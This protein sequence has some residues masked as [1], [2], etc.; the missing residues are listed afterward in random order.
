MKQ[1]NWMRRGGFLALVLALGA[2]RAMDLH[3]LLLPDDEQE[4]AG[5]PQTV[6][7]A[8][9]LL[10]LIDNEVVAAAGKRNDFDAADWSYGWLGLADQELGRYA[11]LG[12]GELQVNAL[13][14]RRVVVVTSSAIR[15][16][17]L[18][19]PQLK[20]FVEDGGLLV[21]ERPTSRWDLLSGVEVA[22][23]HESPLHD[24]TGIRMGQVDDL[25]GI[26][27]QTSVQHL[28]LVRPDVEVLAETE[29]QPVV[30]RRP[31]GKGAVLVLGLDVGRQIV[32]LQ[33]GRPEPGERQVVDRFPRVLGA[34]L[35]SDDLVADARLLSST[36][37]YADVFERFVMAL[38]DET[39]PLPRWWSFPDAAPGAFLLSHDEAGLGD[40]AAWMP[41]AEA[42]RGLLGT[43]FLSQGP[44]LSPLG[45]ERF[46]SAE[47]AGC[48]LGL[49]WNLEPGEE[50]LYEELGLWRVR[51]LRRRVTL[52]R[53]VEWFHALTGE[54]P[55][56]HRSLHQRWTS[57]WMGPFRKMAK[58]GLQIDSSLGPADAR[59]QGYLFGT[60]LPF[61]L[62]DSNGMPLPLRE[63]PFVIAGAQGPDSRQALER[64]LSESQELYHQAVTLALSPADFRAQ[65]TVELY[66]LWKQAFELAQRSGHWVTH[67]PELDAFFSSRREGALSSDF[68]DGRLSVTCQAV[69]AGQTLA[70][71]ARWR[72]RPSTDLR[73]DGEAVRPVQLRGVGGDLLLLP[74]QR[75]AHVVEARYSEMP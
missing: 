31:L 34:G 60:G 29:G 17:E 57:S 70:L 72:G 11:L 67:L 2:L 59:T 12:P 43:C 45:L 42:E 18:W 61:T 74:L 6:R 28:K 71:P 4:Q 75:G 24:L 38:I 14:G 22:S 36:V 26:P 64:L 46:R 25:P 30:L 10:L 27:W 47:G 56:A 16:A 54:A 41:A 19:L 37:P 1:T 33:Q 55:V 51:P 48:T 35:H 44:G 20:L 50:G 49:A 9:D 62:I 8:A 7:Q 53:Q 23:H 39:A 21:L 58:A 66:Q 65:P 73:V 13:D 32:A 3:P 52:Q 69:A 63:L 40:R 15:A 5:S 68:A